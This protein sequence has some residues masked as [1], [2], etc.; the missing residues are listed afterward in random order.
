MKDQTV[1]FTLQLG[2]SQ[3]IMWLVTVNKI[4]TINIIKSYILF[5]LN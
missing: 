5:N 2:K 1:K 4:K 3:K